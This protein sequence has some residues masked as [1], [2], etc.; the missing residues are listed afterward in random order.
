MRSKDV[1][2][3]DLEKGSIIYAVNEASIGRFTIVTSLFKAPPSHTADDCF[4]Y[5]YQELQSFDDI[6]NAAINRSHTFVLH[7]KDFTTGRA[8]FY[9]DLLT[10]VTKYKELNK[11]WYRKVERFYNDVME[12]GYNHE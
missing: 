6:E 4:E 8:Y 12:L 9:H 3:E 1:K 10:A 11:S 5:A 2:F 7:R